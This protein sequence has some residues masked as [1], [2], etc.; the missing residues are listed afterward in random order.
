M[1]N[2][3]TNQSKHNAYYTLIKKG[4]DNRVKESN[5]SARVKIF[6]TE[7]KIKSI[8]TDSPE[9]LII[10]HAKFMEIFIDGYDADEYDSYFSAI[11][12]Q[13]A[14]RTNLDRIVIKKYRKIQKIREAFNY[15]EILSKPK[16]YSLAKTL[17][18]NTC[19]YC[20]RLYTNTVITIDRK[21]KRE[22]NS[23][24]ITRP[25]FDHWF[26]QKK[27]PLLALSYYNLIPCCSVC[28]S[29]IKGDAEF[30]FDTHVHPY[31]DDVINDFSF[32]YIN[33]SI[34]EY[35]VNITLKNDNT[36]LATTLDEF[37]IKEVYNAHSNL[38]LKDLVD[39][40]QK[41][42]ENY[43]DTLFNKTFDRLKVGE[44][45]IY[46]LVFGIESEAANFHKRPF[47]KFKKDIIDELLKDDNLNI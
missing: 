45:E 16:A 47:S 40:K 23:T 35:E 6:L 26:S 42:A 27:Y 9:N 22:N 2:I 19:T 13:K 8:I 12:K 1:L 44:N 43:I 39:L 4:I 5:F 28:N 21:T 3:E 41:Y 18:R 36:K 38:E 37:K 11:L 15:D 14:R 20:N 17:N 34:D 25:Q 7:D 32:T 46:R 29:S 31:I 10:H 30:K 33:K 24:R